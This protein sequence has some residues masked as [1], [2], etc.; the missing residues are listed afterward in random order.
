MKVIENII[1]YFKS[2]FSKQ[3]K[4]TSGEFNKEIKDDNNE[5]SYMDL[6]RKESKQYF[7]KISILDEINKNPELIDTLPYT[8]LV[9]LNEIYSERINELERKISQLL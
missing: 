7:N 2:K 3:K 1:N 6:L 9:Q 4:L 5:N 8:R